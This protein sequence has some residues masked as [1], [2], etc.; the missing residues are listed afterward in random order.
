M[1]F[2]GNS[3]QVSSR[4]ADEPKTGGAVASAVVVGDE[5]NADEG[6]EDPGVVEVV[7][8]ADDAEAVT[9]LVAE[10]AE[11]WDASV[12]VDCPDATDAVA[13]L[14]VAWSREHVL[15]PLHVYPNGQHRSPHVGRLSVNLVVFRNADGLA[16][17]FWA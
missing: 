13:S 14:D 1:A 10:V 5:A 3:G 16:V 4:L 17:A 8:D 7:A 2:A 6:K 11:V 15:F 9:W 12:T